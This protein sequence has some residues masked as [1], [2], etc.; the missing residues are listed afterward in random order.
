MNKNNNLESGFS[1]IE[2]VTVIAML[3]ILATIALFLYGRYEDKARSADVIT[4]WQTINS[5]LSAYLASNFHIDPLRCQDVPAILPSYVMDNKY[6]NLSIGFDQTNPKQTQTVLNI[7]ATSAKPRSFQV[8]EITHDYFEG[9]SKVVP[10][11]IVKESVISFSVPLIDG[12]TCSGQPPAPTSGC[13]ASAAMP[14]NTVPHP[15]PVQPVITASNQPVASSGPP[16]QCGPNQEIVSIVANGQQQQICADKCGQNQ[17]R[18]PK[19]PT[20]C[21][22]QTPQPTAQPIVAAGGSTGGATAQP[23]NNIGSSSGTTQGG[24]ATPLPSPQPP[25]NNGC[26]PGMEIITLHHGNHYYDTCVPVCPPGTRRT[27]GNNAKCH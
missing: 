7:C 11:A 6:V 5:S 17:V 10:G 23:A 4:N 19:D 20:K 9:I 8:A 2:I 21:T 1:L 3:G 18:D 26:G 16:L 12:T 22:A 14:P 15:Q 24:L 25:S 27:S 13:L